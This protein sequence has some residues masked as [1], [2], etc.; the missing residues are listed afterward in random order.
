MLNFISLCM[1]TNNLKQ[2]IEGK[3][4][5]VFSDDKDKDAKIGKDNEKKYLGEAL[6]KD[7]VITTAAPVE[8]ANGEVNKLEEAESAAAVEE[9]ATKGSKSPVVL[10]GKT[11]SSNGVASAC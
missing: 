11:G 1:L 7:K 5:K 3:P 10:S 4:G 9:T 8:E 6:I 2:V